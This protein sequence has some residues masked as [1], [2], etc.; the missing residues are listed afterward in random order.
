MSVSDGALHLAL[1]EGDRTLDACPF[2]GWPAEYRVY[3]DTEYNPAVYCT[4]AACGVVMLGDT[5]EHAYKR[6]QRR[7]EPPCDEECA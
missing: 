7:V 2:C 5:L 4:A 1:R 6:W 3:A